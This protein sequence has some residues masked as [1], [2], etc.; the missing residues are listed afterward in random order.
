MNTT[1]D[2]LLRK[3]S[4]RSF[5]DKKVSNEDLTLLKKATVQAPNGGNMMCYSVLEITEQKQKDALCHLCEDQ[6]MISKAPLV[7]IFLADFQKWDNYFK[8][9]GA[10]ERAR[11]DGIEYR[12][13]GLGDLHIAMQDAIIAAQNAV[14]AAESLGLGSCYI[15]DV[16]MDYDKVSSLL[17]L[18][19][20]TIIAT[21]VV[22]GYPIDP[23]K[24][25][26]AMERCPLE[27]IFHE[28]E[29]K[30]PHLREMQKSYSRMEEKFGRQNRL[31]YG[32]TGTLADYSYLSKHTAPYRRAMNDSAKAFTHAWEQ[33][34]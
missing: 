28:N 10:V 30:E 23:E 7:W 9:S 2:L 8:E 31:P 29:Y 25:P 14:I 27:A 12:A 11:R 6:V 26:K 13:P 16:I 20:Y 32:N 1:I 18:T 19:P 34:D 24:R 17:K 21:M 22:F 33:K 5:S 15:G 4:L 3:T